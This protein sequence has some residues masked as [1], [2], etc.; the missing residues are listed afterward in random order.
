MHDIS[1]TDNK[2]IETISSY[3]EY[4]DEGTQAEIKN[5]LT[6]KNEVYKQY[7][8][9]LDELKKNLYK[10]I[11]ECSDIMQK[12]SKDD[13]L[14]DAKSKNGYKKYKLLGETKNINANIAYA[15]HRFYNEIYSNIIDKLKKRSDDTSPGES[16]AKADNTRK[17]NLAS[18]NTQALLP[19]MDAASHNG[20]ASDEQEKSAP[21]AKK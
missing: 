11:A 3:S 8:G 5:L 17:V 19:K 4:T 12:A 7:T 9:D 2:T 15:L 16:A 18:Q 14:V 13:T 6:E 21:T 10:I 20:D 1:I